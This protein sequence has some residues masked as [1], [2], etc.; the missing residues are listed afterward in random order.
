[1]KLTIFQSDKGDCLLLEAQ[2]GELM[3][4][5]GG[6]GPSMRT[7]VRAEL[8]ALRKQGRPLDL[9]YISHI[10]NDHIG[11]ILQLLED[12]AEWRVFDHHEKNG[13]PVKM[14]NM[15]RPPDIKGILYNG[16][17]DQIKGN[18]SS[19]EN[20]IAAQTIEN[21]LVGMAPSLFATAIPEL[22]QVADEMQSIATGV[23]EGIQVSQLIDAKLLNIPLNQ[24]PGVKKSSNLLYAGR[25]GEIF[26]LGSMKF[27][28]LGPT[29]AELTKLRKG[30]KH[31][32]ANNPPRVNQIRAELQKRVNDFST[33]VL[34][35]SPFDLTGW[36]GVPNYKGVT[37]P[38][39]ASLMWMVEEDEGDKRKRCLLT[40]DGQQDFI[41]AGLMRSG[42]LAKNAEDG[43]HLDV[44]KVQH[45]G[46]PNNLKADFAKRV[47]AD[48]YVFCGDGE[49]TNPD[50]EVINLI[51][52]SRLGKNSKVQTL[53][54]RAK[55]R[56]FHFWFST[57]STAQTPN[58]EKRKYFER[59]EKRVAELVKSSNGKLHPHYNKNTSIVL[60]I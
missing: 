8:G 58:T 30:W 38:N 56:E 16:F 22:I 46:S 45:H 50:I 52:N 3:L 59:V 6:M 55:D 7:Q 26:D 57:T 44:L 27:T 36:E 17:R 24:P 5:D 18:E 15:P 41:L 12:E 43:L 35:G 14:P 60:D 20:L 21:L 31:W 47:S 13:H 48:H 29:K 10:D 1:M 9:V 34:A 49:H 53:A 4:C 19:T 23:P 33:G 2:S 32:L 51:Y 42:F 37:V 25:P 39:I 11:G 40:G 54:P 28:L